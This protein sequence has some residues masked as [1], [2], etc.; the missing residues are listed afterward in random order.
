M[1]FSET[2]VPQLRKL[3]NLRFCALNCGMPSTGILTSMLSLMTWLPKA[4]HTFV[5]KERKLYHNYSMSLIPQK[6]IAN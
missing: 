3:R 4:I 5:G 6:L 2:Q 1:Q